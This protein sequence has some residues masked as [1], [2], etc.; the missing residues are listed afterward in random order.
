VGDRQVAPRRQLRH[1]ARDKGRRVI[2]VIDQVQDADQHQ[3]DRPGE[4]DG[5]RGAGQDR[6][7][8]TQVGFQ[9]GAR[10]VGSR[11]QQRASV[12]E[13]DRVV[14]H[15]DDP[16]LGCHQLGDLVGIAGRRDSGADIEELADARVAGEEPYRA[17]EEGAVRLDRETQPRQ[18][19]E[20]PLGG[21]AVRCEVVLP[22]QPVVIDPG[23]VC[24]ARVKP[25]LL[26]HE[27][28]VTTFSTR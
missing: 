26:L 3:R 17:R 4:V 8:V 12:V 7:R 5:L 20:R 22:A 10:A 1:Q 15:V 9:V 27:I 24:D 28:R 21:L 23:G 19:R 6:I 14:V 25:R 16:R 11:G 13:D 2:L 18:H